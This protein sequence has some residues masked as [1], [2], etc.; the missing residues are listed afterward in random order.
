MSRWSLPNYDE[1]KTTD[2]NEIDP[3][4]YHC[5]TCDE[6]GEDCTCETDEQDWQEIDNEPDEPDDFDDYDVCDRFYSP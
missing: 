2:P 4:D 6:N 1:W 5:N 3:A